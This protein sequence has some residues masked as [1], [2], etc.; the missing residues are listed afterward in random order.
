MVS[1]YC[2]MD[3]VPFDER[4]SSWRRPLVRSAEKANSWNSWECVVVI[5]CRSLLQ[6]LSFLANRRRPC[7]Y[8]CY[9]HLVKMEATEAGTLGPYSL[10]E[11][12]KLELLSEQDNK[13]WTYKS[14]LSPKFFN[15]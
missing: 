13:K 9:R 10:D 8:P 14:T 6:P 12:L 3:N 7:F 15:R 5:H 11:A 2:T 1:L 4:A